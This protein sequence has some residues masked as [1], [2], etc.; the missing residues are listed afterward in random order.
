MAA[1]S[2]RIETVVTALTYAIV[3]LAFAMVARAVGLTYALIFLFLCAVALVFER[4][5][6]EM[7]PRWL[8]NLTAIAFIIVTVLR[9]SFADPVTPVLQM[10]LL[11]TGIKLLEKKGF[12]D[13]M[14]IYLLA[15]FLLAGSA[16]VSIDMDF[17]AALLVLMYLLSTAIIFLT[18][19]VQESSLEVS[20]QVLRRMLSASLLIPTIAIPLSLLL[21]IVLPR[22]TFPLMT[23][24][25]RGSGASTG[26]SEEISLGDVAGI[27]EDASIAFRAEMPQVEDAD[28]YWRGIVL[29]IFDGRK[30]TRAR[31]E[32]GAAELRAGQGRSVRQVIYLEP[33]QNRYLFALDRPISVSPQQA[34]IDRDLTISLPSAFERRIRYEAYSALAA[35][36]ADRDEPASRYTQLPDKD[37]DKIRKHM[38]SLVDSQG[39]LASAVVLEEH[40]RDSGI[41]T[42]SLTSLPLTGNPL[43]EFFFGKRT[44]NCE[45]FASA[46]A[47]MLRLNDIPARLVGGYRGGYYSELGGYYAIPQKSAHVWV[48]AYFPG[49]G[50][51]RFDP[52]PALSET[53]SAAIQRSL[54]LRIRM[55]VDS[56]QYAWNAFVINYD[57]EKQVR[58]FQSMGNRLRGFDSSFAPDRKTIIILGSVL[59]VVVIAGCGLRYLKNR[60][61]PEERILEQYLVCLHRLG[62][63]RKS[64]EGLSEM[65]SRIVQEDLRML[66]AQFAEVYQRCFYRDG[67]FDEKALSVLTTVLDKIKKIQQD[68]AIIFFNFIIFLISGLFRFLNI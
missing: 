9:I 8:L 15:V 30:W 26:F 22:S 68:N 48:E 5:P 44:G 46:L 56:I 63:T 10:L 23:F 14:Q 45:Y 67:I 66:A 64:G 29:E 47:V 38:H 41:Y 16:L 25:N 37:L 58:L 27:Q 42:Y 61:R 12:R 43:H 2:I 52:T 39:G 57:F 3:L 13:F 18:Y 34:R 28:L 24:L 53:Y 59:A 11:L 36:M 51:V 1:H 17:L 55:L 33:Y 4:R 60:K 32:Q 62:S 20:R 7:I 40:L 31:E 19:Y 65:T 50:W 54:V 35:E 21:F 49:R 6:S